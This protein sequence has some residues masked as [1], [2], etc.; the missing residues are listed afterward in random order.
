MSTTDSTRAERDA[1]L[2]SPAP[3]PR[4]RARVLALAGGGVLLILV[5]GVALLPSIASR[6]APGMI[7]SSAAGQVQGRLTVAGARFSW[8]GPQE[9]GP[10]EI[11][12]PAGTPVGRLSVKVAS[13][14]LGLVGRNLGTAA[15]SG[16]LDLVREADGTT[17]LERALAPV[18]VKVAGPGPAAAPGTSPP[19]VPVGYAAGL[20]LDG[21]E[22]TYTELD[23]A[24]APARQ[25]ALTGLKGAANVSTTAPG[26][27]ALNLSGNVIDTGK[28][29]GAIK[30]NGT[31]DAFTDARGNLTPQS[32][33]VSADVEVAGVPG[34]LLDALLGQR[35]LLA[36]ALGG[37]VSANVRAAGTAA[38]GTASVLVDTP[39]VSA[40]VAVKLDGGVVRLEKPGQFTVRSTRFAES[41][42]AVREALTR[43]GMTLEQWPGV[44]GTIDALALTV[45]T[46]PLAEADLRGTALALTLGTTPIA[47]T[48]TPPGGGGGGG[49]A[50][51]F[52]VAPVRLSIAAP[53]LAKGVELKAATSATL[54]GQSAGAITLSATAADLLDGQGRAPALRGTLPTNLAASVQAKG[55]STALLQ[56]FVAG[57]NPPLE[58]AADIGPTLDAAIDVR[59]DATAGA[60]G[61]AGG[62]T[63]AATIDS[64]NVKL[65]APLVLKNN[66][67]ATA[68]G[69]LTVSIRSGA[70][71]LAR[72]LVAPPRPA[73]EGGPAI[74]RLTGAGAIEASV[75]DLA[76]VLPVR[77]AKTGAA[78]P[79]DAGALRA[80]VNARLADVALFMAAP[81]AG[82][83]PAEPVKV[84]T[85]TLD[86]TAKQGA[87]PQVSL[88]GA[89]A[90]GGRPFEAAGTVQIAGLD[91]ALSASGAAKPG[92]LI[93]G[94]QTV[95]LSGQLLLSGVP[96][97]LAGLLHPPATVEMARGA[98]GDTVNVAVLFDQPVAG[99]AADPARQLVDATAT[100]PGLNAR[101]VVDL[102]AV[103]LRVREM[104]A[105]ATVRPETI[106]ALT[107][108]APG[109]AGGIRVNGPARIEIDAQP[110][111]I[112]VRVAGNAVEPQFA[113]AGVLRAAVAV[114]GVL[115]VSDIP[116]GD[117]RMAGG[118]R[119]FALEVSFPLAV[120]AAPAPAGQRVAAAGK[121]TLMLDERTIVA[122]LAL[123]A[124]AA[125]DQSVVDAKVELAQINTVALDG[126]LG[127]PGLASGALGERASLAATA[128]RT[129]GAD[130][131]L[132]LAASVSSPRLETGVLELKTDAARLA[133]A[134]PASVRWTIDP[135]WAGRYLLTGK[136]KA[137]NPVPPALQLTQPVVVA[138][139]LRALAVA[140]PETRGGLAVSGP[141]KPGV[142]ALDA[143][144]A[145][146]R[147][148]VL[149][150]PPPG[151]SEPARPAALVD[152]KAAVRS[153]ADAGLAFEA[154]VGRVDAGAGPQAPG[155]PVTATGTLRGIAYENGTVEPRN[156]VVSLNV[157]APRFPAQVVDALAGAKGQIVQTLGAEMDLSV[158]AADASLTGGT[159]DVRLTS[160]QAAGAGGRAGAAASEQ[161]RF[162]VGGPIKDAVLDVAGDGARQP[163]NLALT[164]FRYESS[165]T[166]M[167]VLPLF[168]SISK[169]VGGGDGKPV[170][171]TSSN[172]RAPVDG[173]MENLN[174]DI[175]VD[176]GLIQYQFKEALGEFLDATVFTAGTEPQKPIAPF[177]IAV[178]SGVATYERF[179]IPIRQFV[180]STRG[181]VDL[182]RNEVDVITYI[183]TVA[184]SK[185]L[186]GRVSGEASKGLGGILPN[187]LTEGTMIPIRA[188]G[189]L[190][191]PRIYPDFELFFKEIGKGLQKQPE[192]IIE[193]VIDLF[194]RKK[195]R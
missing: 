187:A 84:E 146:A 137:G 99:A 63:V 152:V 3:R 178:R 40:T 159:V 13:S 94:V 17:N 148:D 108:S 188:K 86:L 96:V 127:Q 138:A 32:A 55:V 100:S 35:G 141:L 22:I 67:L 104:T 52:N 123:N 92:A 157:S 39:N 60:A 145:V 140:I 57:M 118:L 193:N 66:T 64:A 15:L 70:P 192:K 21:L 90:H 12:D 181:T 171:I 115:S 91:A 195:P 111:S 28:S 87:A 151:K 43:A 89:L 136:D 102:N 169:N 107:G 119:D 163:L 41:V 23:A 74:T 189:P 174:G 95:R 79:F 191:N 133:L 36:G 113:G 34:A 132:V 56:P 58:L 143:D 126:V 130:K 93:P 114:P 170:M 186:L 156:A 49:T 37:S 122:E 168:A 153:T 173:R 2:G 139:N 20:V 78:G 31:L 164:S 19:A 134:K 61:D 167:K 175:V 8:S 161:A 54:N 183:P 71:L 177:T 101:L 81:E 121:G 73:A 109:A 11:A 76:V 50:Q 62:L 1:L 72:Y 24:G 45:P 165:A 25:T 42:P 59:S 38:A 129:G 106:A 180:L 149:L 77:D 80:R 150:L 18:G 51:P 85:L 6:L 135:A 5:L 176:L 124:T 144:V 179:D 75:S 44:E 27:A 182:V 160:R 16:K 110:V 184:A 9:I 53:D 7:Q 98:V 112:P 48:L 103:E 128:V 26:T 4:R 154:S 172:L 117:K 155:Q 162:A 105:R 14:L 120:L 69:P 194:G 33:K 158:K 29:A 47:G 65:S 166:I 10:I 190:D 131:P 125:P 88:K 83:T 116:V 82:A 185:A 142:F 68:G 147:V 97:S 46:G 30:I